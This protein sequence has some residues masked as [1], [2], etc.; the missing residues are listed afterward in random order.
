MSGA[1]AN[2][3][4]NQELRGLKKG[5]ENPGWLETESRGAGPGSRPPLKPGP[6]VIFRFTPDG[7]FTF[8]NPTPGSDARTPEDAMG[9]RAGDPALA[10]VVSDRLK[11]AVDALKTGRAMRHEYTLPSA[12]GPRS[13]E[14]LY[15]PH[16]AGEVLGVA[17]DVSEHERMARELVESKEKFHNLMAGS[18]QGVVV[19]RDLH[20]LF[21]NQTMADI[22]GCT[23]EE[24]LEL[25][26]MLEIFHPDEHARLVE[27]KNARMR[28][29]YAPSEYEVRGV[30]KEGSIIWLHCGIMRINWRGAPAIQM[31]VFDITE[32]KLAEEE[33]IR[34]NRDLQQEIRVR[35]RAEEKAKAANYAKSDFL[36][37]MSHELRTPLNAVTGFSELLSF[38][39]TDTK[40]K[41]Y[42]EAIKT[43]GKSLLTLIND[44]LDLSKIE[45]G[46][47]DIEYA[48]VNPRMIITEI[49]QIFKMKTAGKTLGFIVDIAPDIP[50][51]L[52]LDETRLRQILLNLVGNALKFTER[53]YIKLSA[54]R[55]PHKSDSDKI[56]LVVTVE[57]TGSG[58]SREDQKRIFDAFK[59]RSGQDARKYGGAGLGL[60]I[61]KRLTEM[62]N[63]E[64]SVTSEPD[65][66]AVFE[67]LLRE[68]GVSLSE[69]LELEEEPF[70]ITE[71]SFEKGKVLV[72]DDVHSNRELIRELL[73][74]VNLGVLTAENGQEAIIMA[75]EY[76]P[77]V[78][79][80]DIRMP[81]M[82]GI[83]ATKLL[84]RYPETKGIPIVALTASA[85]PR[86][87]EEL[88]KSGLSGYLTKPVRLPA[89]FGELS[90]WLKR[91]DEATPPRDDHEEKDAPAHP[92]SERIEK[93]S[94]LLE[95]TRTEMLPWR[96]KIQ[97]VMKITDLRLFR[98]RIKQLGEEYN[99]PQFIA[100][101]EKMEEYESS[102]NVA[103]I[104][105]ALAEFPGIV[106]ELENQIMEQVGS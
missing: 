78:I 53:G 20:P 77:D 103:N 7:D 94:R 1:P 101:A 93:F 5:A 56:D 18:I 63:G 52:M 83:E 17:R 67:I 57:D 73:T 65:Q 28:G 16:G 76:Q 35:K 45:A 48:P 47:M 32:R 42:L 102:F 64:I 104:E 90:K 82:D 58:I 69:V 70:D 34:I 30:R 46:R 81:V 4:L 38:V 59:Q 21:A 91:A 87:R 97:G 80:M 25:D 43:A 9:G 60:S 3:N 88:M 8:L 99:A 29:D 40:Q 15:I 6:D 75:G 31:T 106:E 72:V 11:L 51:A 13:I 23:R 37:N 26:T 66:G 14:A 19:H 85:R 33:L 36:A 27:Y 92:S 24:I 55:I 96:E 68:V 39:V 12:D 10:E 79:L 41:G 22:I 61:C 84:K 89:L 71:I 105:K 86:D 74:K 100:F 2:E 62:M 50:P 49:E 95:I 54:K 98:A 44:I